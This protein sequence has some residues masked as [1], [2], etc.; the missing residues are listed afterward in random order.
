MISKGHVERELVFE[1]WNVMM[2]E[3]SSSISFA[4]EFHRLCSLRRCLMRVARS[5]FGLDGVGVAPDRLAA[6]RVRDVAWLGR[7]QLGL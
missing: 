2:H 1:G 4:S 3:L 7:R 5:I 6:R